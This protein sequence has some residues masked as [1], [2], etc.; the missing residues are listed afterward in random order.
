MDSDYIEARNKLIRDACIAEEMFG[1]DE[2][3]EYANGLSDQ[4]V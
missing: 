2:L 3:E 1:L 4:P